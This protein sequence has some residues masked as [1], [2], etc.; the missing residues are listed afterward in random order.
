MNQDNTRLIA[1]R[2]R[3]ALGTSILSSQP[4]D[5]TGGGYRTSDTS[6]APYLQQAVTTTN[7][8]LMAMSYG[9]NGR[10]FSLNGGEVFAE[11][12]SSYPGDEDIGLG[13]RPHD[14]VANIDGWLDTYL[15][16]PR[17][18][19]DDELRA[20]SALI[21]EPDYDVVLL[22]GQSNMVGRGLITSN[23]IYH[24]ASRQF[25][26]SGQ[27]A[28]PTDRD[29]AILDLD[30]P[31]EGRNDENGSHGLAMSFGWDYLFAQTIPTK[32]VLFVPCAV[33]GSSFSRD[34][35]NKGDPEYEFAV[36]QANSAIAE[37]GGTL[38]AILWHQ[39]ETDVTDG[40]TASYESQLDQMISDLRSDITG[41]S[42]VPFVLGGLLP[43]FVTSNGSDGSTI[44]A[45]IAD[46][47]NRVANCAYAANT[48]L[49][50]GDGVHFDSDSLI[51]LG[52]RY[53]TA[54]ASL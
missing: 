44:Q 51:T 49:T 5:Q 30:H 22:A 19:T 52:I 2:I 38:R 1:H 8:Q 25:A 50:G 40:N 11:P 17:D 20:N 15:Y 31:D 54:L 3:Y 43:A 12:F 47:P 37:S 23:M 53:Y 42:S 36:S 16:L 35:W 21:G 33:G 14:G 18:L 24:D 6:T 4:S 41:A 46:T 9:A 13:A 27:I 32:R 39:G 29:T 7:R 34:N 26:Q 48:S 10:R 45:I 28:E